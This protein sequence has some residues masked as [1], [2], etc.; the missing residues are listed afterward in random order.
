MPA[1]TIRAIRRARGLSAAARAARLDISAYCRIER[2]E[3]TG[4][5]PTLRRIAAALA[6]PLA[7]LL[8]LEEDDA[9]GRAAASPPPVP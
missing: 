6:V 3:R 8:D 2:G 7:R 1:T 4:T 5:I 9:H